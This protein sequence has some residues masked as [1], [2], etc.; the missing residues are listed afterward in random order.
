MLNLL[1]IK[2]L[3]LSLKGP[4][5]ASAKKIAPFKIQNYLDRCFKLLKVKASY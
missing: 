2:S 3:R 1:T 5:L 4:K